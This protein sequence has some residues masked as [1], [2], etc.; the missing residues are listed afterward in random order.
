MFTPMYAEVIKNLSLLLCVFFKQT[1][2]E[3]VFMVE[4]IF[5]LFGHWSVLVMG[6]FSHI[7]DSTDDKNRTMKVAITNI[8]CILAEPVGIAISGVLLR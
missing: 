6:A 5:P 3:V 4:N 8:L 7:M 1:T 2:G